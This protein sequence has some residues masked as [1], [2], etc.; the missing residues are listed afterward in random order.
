MSC[1]PS[2]LANPNISTLYLGFELLVLAHVR[3]HP[4]PPPLK[5]SHKKQDSDELI[6]DLEHQLGD[7]M[8]Q[9]LNIE[10]EFRHSG[11]P[12]VD[13]PLCSTGLTRTKTKV[14]THA[15]A[16]I[17]RH[18]TSSLWSPPPVPQANPLF[19]IIA[20]NWGADAANDVMHRILTSRSIPRKAA[21][22]SRRCELRIVSS[23]SDAES[24]N[25]GVSR[26]A[27]PIPKRQASLQRWP[28]P[29][30]RGRGP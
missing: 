25:S 30:G 4:V 13:Q 22:A 20:M 10:V 17:K 7:T 21:R 3:L 15:A 23:S 29:L 5:Q 16:V 1:I 11:F 26:T 28:L 24:A 14:Q 12:E 6:Q 8:T 2:Y 27:P 19:A 9:Y 18:N